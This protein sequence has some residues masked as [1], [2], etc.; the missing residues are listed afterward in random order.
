VRGGATV[1]TGAGATVTTGAAVAGGDVAGADGDAGDAG[2]AGAEVAGLE[3]AGELELPPEEASTTPA[4]DAFE[5]LAD[6]DEGPLGEVDVPGEAVAGP[7]PAAGSAAGSVAVPA[8]EDASEPSTAGAP[9][10][11]SSRVAEFAPLLC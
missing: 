9:V 7:A 10:T 2:D 3:A 8:V 4:A 5:E 11:F 6:D 1:V